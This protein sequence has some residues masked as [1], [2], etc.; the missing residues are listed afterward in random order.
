MGPAM[1]AI[2]TGAIAA[3]IIYILYRRFAGGAG[4]VFEKD[5][6]IAGRQAAGAR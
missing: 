3:I 2:I 5:D 6:A 4:T 1:S